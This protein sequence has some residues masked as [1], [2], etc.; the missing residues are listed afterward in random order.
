VGAL[1]CEGFVA[2]ALMATT[3]APP[4]SPSRFLRALGQTDDEKELAAAKTVAQAQSPSPSR[5]LRALGQSGDTKDA[6]VAKTEPPCPPSPLNVLPPE[7]PPSAPQMLPQ[8][9]DMEVGGEQDEDDAADGDFAAEVDGG[10]EASAAAV[11]PL[12]HVDA[13]VSEF[14][15]A[16]SA[17][18]S[19]PRPLSASSGEA[20]KLVQALLESTQDRDGCMAA[21]QAI[22]IATARSSTVHRRLL[23]AHGAEALVAAMSA[24]SDVAE[25]Q[26][27]A[28]HA[29][30]HLATAASCGGAARVADAGGCEAML[31]AL[32][33][34]H[35]QDPL[36]AQAAA[37]ALELVAFGGPLPRGRAVSDGAVE[38]LL[39]ALK[40]HRANAAVQLAVLAALQ[41]VVE[42][43]PDCQQIDRVSKCNGINNIVSSLGEHKSD[44]QVQY[45][46][47]LLL[48]GICASNRD[49]RAEALRKL[50]YQGIEL[51]L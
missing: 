2:Q 38:V 10:Y 29:L 50:H 42:R 4:P 3:E 6:T 36:L 30:Q 15:A 19:G 12:A 14:P 31:L 46:G 44:K 35:S 7:Q 45:W 33:P 28:C 16:P 20:K 34:A 51:E 5:F 18:S 21:C 22:E 39:S 8:V 27:I 37:H 41:T 9:D 49:L 1:S 48:Q 26:L 40:A 13:T 25:I 47:R 11:A 24:H 23:A 43:N 32:G 17:P